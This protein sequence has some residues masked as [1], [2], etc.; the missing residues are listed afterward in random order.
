MKCLILYNI[1][2]LS[3][4]EFIESFKEI[5]QIDNIN[6]NDFIKSGINSYIYINQNIINKCLTNNYHL[7][8]LEF[9][10]L[11]IKKKYLPYINIIKTNVFEIIEKYNNDINSY[12]LPKEVNLIEYL[13]SRNT[14]DFLVIK[15]NNIDY[16]KDT[17]KIISDKNNIVN[18][19]SK[20]YPNYSKYEYGLFIETEYSL[21]INNLTLFLKKEAN[22]ILDKNDIIDTKNE[23]L[24]LIINQ[25]LINILL[26]TDTYSLDKYTNENITTS[27]NYRYKELEDIFGYGNKLLIKCKSSKIYLLIDEDDV[28][29]EDKTI[30]NISWKE[31]YKELKKGNYYIV[32][33]CFTYQELLENIEYE[34]YRLNNMYVINS[35]CKPFISYFN[36][37]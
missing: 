24:Y 5:I 15:F 27:I 37:I 32:P 25:K 34:S 22:Y 28:D 18:I 7:Y 4:N 21:D 14:N 12:I 17:S 10:F 3:F 8:R 19:F 13:Y 9:Y 33:Q 35:Y 2:N 11:D 31:W 36:Y 6:I 23:N 20:N 1:N 26:D 30:I 29:Y 16:F